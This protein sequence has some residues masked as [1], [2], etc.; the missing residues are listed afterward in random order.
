MTTLGFERDDRLV[1]LLL[2]IAEAL[3]GLGIVALL[4][5]FLPTM[6]GHFSKREVLVTQLHNWASESDGTASPVTMLIR[7]HRING[8]ERLHDHLGRLGALVRRARRD[9]QLVPGADVLSLPESRS[10]MGDDVRCRARCSIA[11]SLLHQH[12]A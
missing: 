5:S 1:V 10:F 3:I 8:F 6:Y 7:A 2:V 12:A 4:I 11:I 9:S